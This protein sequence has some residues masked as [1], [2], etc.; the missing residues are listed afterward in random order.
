[1]L[2]VRALLVLSL[3]AWVRLVSL[4]LRVAPL[5]EQG[6]WWW[7]LGRGGGSLHYRGGL[8]THARTRTAGSVSTTSYFQ[9]SP[10]QSLPNCSSCVNLSMGS[11]GSTASSFIATFATA[12]HASLR[13]GQR[14][15]TAA[16]VCV[17]TL[18]VISNEVCGTIAAG[19][20]PITNTHR[21]DY[22]TLPNHSD[23]GLL[24]YRQRKRARKDSNDASLPYR[25]H[26]T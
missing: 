21:L 8:R 1:M 9:P 4:Q 10:W 22:T 19:R 12:A 24:K 18:R 20:I 23:L 2:A 17:T 3:P 25:V 16:S 26:R 13:Q 5:L 14:F 7:C 15:F 11:V 6:G